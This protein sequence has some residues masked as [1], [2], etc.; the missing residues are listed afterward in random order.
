MMINT[1]LLSL[2]MISAPA[3]ARHHHLHEYGELR[4]SERQ[5]HLL[6]IIVCL[7][8]T[9]IIVAAPNALLS[10]LGPE[11]SVAA[12][13]LVILALGQLVNIWLPTQDMMLAMTG[14]G[15]LLQRVNMYQLA[16]CSVLSAILIPTLGL[17]GVGL[18]STICLIQGR[19][20]FALAVRRVIPQLSAP[21]AANERVSVP[22]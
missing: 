21:M 2:A 18:V 14:Y 9:I 5:T 8:I 4:R 7:P 17:L 20:G 6:A 3:F 13:T 16:T 1:I 10:L 22:R 12:L 19:I 11:Y 15:R